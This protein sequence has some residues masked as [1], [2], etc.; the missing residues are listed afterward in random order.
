[1][2]E[3][4]VAP[5]MKA[6]TKRK[7]EKAKQGEIQNKNLETDLAEEQ[8]V[9]MEKKLEEAVD[10]KIEEGQ[11]SDCGLKELRIGNVQMQ[12]EKGI[13]EKMIGDAQSKKMP[14]EELLAGHLAQ[15]VIEAFGVMNEAMG[16]ASSPSKLEE[17]FKIQLKSKLVGAEPPGDNHAK[18]D[19][20]N[21]GAPTAEK[22]VNDNAKKEGEAA[23]E[24]DQAIIREKKGKTPVK[25]VT[26][27]NGPEEK[28]CKK[29]LF[30]KLKENAEMGHGE[31]DHLQRGGKDDSQKSVSR[32]GMKEQGKQGEGKD[33]KEGVCG[34]VPKENKSQNTGVG[35][36]GSQAGRV[37]QGNPWDGGNPTFRGRGTS[38]E[39]NNGP[40]RRSASINKGSQNQGQAKD[41]QQN[42]KMGLGSDKFEKTKEGGEAK[43]SQKVGVNQKKVGEHFEKKN[44]ENERVW[45]RGQTSGLQ[46]PEKGFC[47]WGGGRGGSRG[48]W[49][50]VTGQRGR[51]GSRGSEYVREKIAISNPFGTL[52]QQMDMRLGCSMVL[53]SGAEESGI[54][55]GDECLIKGMREYVS[56]MEA[57]D[58]NDG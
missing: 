19:H 27:E 24:T 54:E 55:W 37:G 28:S 10:C 33:S 43:G 6:V 35:R 2:A 23:L 15:Q 41:G 13:M 12:V 11:G 40:R 26:F 53:L 3:P 45:E 48:G 7:L 14:M 58:W 52:N 5:P 57:D 25:G 29:N 8:A 22:D 44:Q 56:G 50:G 9:G 31:G 1:M 39:K 4:P 18:E 30:G 46:K 21:Q 34:N 42:A 51:G 36:G 32:E 20:K 38:R 49:I 16:G 47:D 17:I